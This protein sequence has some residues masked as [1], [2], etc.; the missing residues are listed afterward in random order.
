MEENKYTYSTGGGGGSS[1]PK[2]KER[3][4]KYWTFQYFGGGYSSEAAAKKAYG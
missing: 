3:S 4:D 2:P 1:T